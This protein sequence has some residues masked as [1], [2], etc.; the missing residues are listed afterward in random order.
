MTVLPHPKAPGMAV[1]PPCTHLHT[2]TV[3]RK[4][5]GISAVTDFHG[6]GYIAIVH[7]GTHFC[8]DLLAIFF[9]TNLVSKYIITEIN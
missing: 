9:Q 6:L 3:E 8:F 7:T 2:Q 1:V 5:V 4:S